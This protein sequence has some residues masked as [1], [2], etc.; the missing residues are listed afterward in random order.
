MRAILLLHHNQAPKPGTTESCFIKLRLLAILALVFLSGGALAQVQETIPPF[1]SSGQRGTAT[2]QTP[3][4]AKVEQHRATEALVDA[5]SL[6][7]IASI[8]AGSD[9]RSFLAPGVPQELTRAALRRAWVTDPAIRDFVGRSE[10]CWDFTAPDGAP[11]S[12]PG[13][14]DGAAKLPVGVLD[15]SNSRDGI[16]SVQ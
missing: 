2:A 8:E 4:I 6:P 16:V 14:T 3:V 5:A 7:P 13:A 1:L 12:A 15:P 11:G 10:N 9:I